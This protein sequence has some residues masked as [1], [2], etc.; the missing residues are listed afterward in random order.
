MPDPR[1]AVLAH[2][3]TR[4]A[5]RVHNSHCL[6]TSTCQSS[7]VTLRTWEPRG[8]CPGAERGPVPATARALHELRRGMPTRRVP[9]SPLGYPHRGDGDG[10]RYSPE[11]QGEFAG[12]R[13]RMSWEEQV[14]SEV[15]RSVV[16]FGQTRRTCAEHRFLSPQTFLLDL[17]GVPWKP[18]YRVERRDRRRRPAIA[19]RRPSRTSGTPVADQGQE[20]FV[21]D[22]HE[23]G[24]GHRSLGHDQVVADQVRG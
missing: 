21:D 7:V 5:Y 10:E 9:V 12:L 17:T 19:A 13:E 24:V 2:R 3:T 4:T 23:S 14:R 18:A 11:R 16:L 22:L 6:T 1:A 8:L 20:D 15:L